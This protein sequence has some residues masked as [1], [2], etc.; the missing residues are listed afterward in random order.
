[1][2]ATGERDVS[3]WLP[4]N[5]TKKNVT[6]NSRNQLRSTVLLKGC[7]G[8]HLLFSARLFFLDC[9]KQSVLADECYN[10]IVCILYGYRLLPRIRATQVTDPFYLCT[11]YRGGEISYH[12]FDKH[13]DIGVAIPK[14]A[15]CRIDET[16]PCFAS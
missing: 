10:V 1:M 6:F 12:T 7:T 4:E 8:L 2:F 13:T 9:V 5:S 3:S 16:N 14:S 11:R 15:L